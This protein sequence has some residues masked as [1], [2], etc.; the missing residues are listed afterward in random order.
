MNSE[1]FHKYDYSRI[2]NRR[3]YGR[4]LQFIVSHCYNCIHV[5]LL[6]ITP[7]EYIVSDMTVKTATFSGGLDWIADPTDVAW[8][9]P[10]IQQHV[11]NKIITDYDHTDFMWATNAANV[12][13]P[14]VINLINTHS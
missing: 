8:L 5:L 6:Q 13:Y 2:G 12:I 1:R 9:R 4:V 10:Q 3:H 7:P 11:F 14:D